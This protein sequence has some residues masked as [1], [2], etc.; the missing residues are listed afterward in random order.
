MGKR[1]LP[2]TVLQFKCRQSWALVAHTY[3]PS[4]SEGRDQEDLGL[5]PAQ[6]NSSQDP[7]LKTPIIKKGWWSG[8]SVGPEFKLQY[9]KKK[10]FLNTDSLLLGVET[11]ESAKQ[12][13]VR[14]GTFCWQRDR[15][16]GL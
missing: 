8:S 12:V 2:L 11:Q 7:S 10:F 1:Y 16:D 5:K 3:N 13:L 15:V 6:A 9:Y 4:Y 14:T